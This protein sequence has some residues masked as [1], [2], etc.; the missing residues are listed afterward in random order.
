MWTRIPEYFEKEVS[1]N[2]EICVFAQWRHVIFDY[3]WQPIPRLCSETS[4]LFVFRN[5]GQGHAHN[6]FQE[7]FKFT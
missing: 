3:V 2:L 6:A 1:F 4:A 7:I 5:A